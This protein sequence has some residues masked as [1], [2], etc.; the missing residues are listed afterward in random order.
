MKRPLKYKPKKYRPTRDM[1]EQ[2]ENLCRMDKCSK[3]NGTEKNI[4]CADCKVN[5]RF[6]ELTGADI[7]DVLW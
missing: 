4:Y 6:K 3:I 2:L 5:K 7:R 1:M